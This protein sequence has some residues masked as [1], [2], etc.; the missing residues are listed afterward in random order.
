MDVFAFLAALVALV[1]L[2]IAAFNVA[3]RVNL[4]ALGL[5]FLVFAWI[6]ELSARNTT[7]IHF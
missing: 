4:V 6:V 3:A 2:A 5:A 7:R 1:L